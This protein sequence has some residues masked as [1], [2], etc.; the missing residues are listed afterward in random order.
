MRLIVRLAFVVAAWSVVGPVRAAD[1]LPSWNEG[2]AKTAILDF[3]TRST[4]EGGADFVP[5]AERIATF[6][7]DGTLWSEKPVYFQFAFVIDRI[8]VLADQHPEW[9]DREPYKSVLA[10][11]LKAAVGGG[12]HAIAELV[13]A[14]QAGL[15]T[16]EFSAIVRDW[17]KM[18]RHP[19]FDRPYTDL[20]FQP[21]LKLLALMRANGFKT[22]MLCRKPRFV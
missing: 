6:D 4:Q 21:M 11:D 15:T 19:R 3:V 10:G 16:D 7:N 13:M 9:R 8:K 17:L 5:P 18:A 14:T 1:P 2:A 22:Y 20:V 12:E